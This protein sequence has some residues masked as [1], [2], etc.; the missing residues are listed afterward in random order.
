MKIWHQSFT[1]LE[2][3]PPY[4]AALAAH[5]K[6][7]ARPDTEVVLHGM[8]PDTY[9]TEYPG[10]DIKFSYFQTLHSQQFVLAALQAEQDGFDAL[11]I[12]TLPEPSFEDIRAIVDIPVV[13][14]CESA[15]LVSALVSR[16]CG[17][18]LFIRDMAPTIVRNVARMGLGDRFIGAQDVGFTFND[19]LAAYDDAT[20]LLQKFRAAARGMIAQGADA[21]IPGEA[22]L[23]V[24]L[25]RHGVTN[26][27]GVPVIDALAATV[28]MAELSVDLRRSSGLAPAKQGYFTAKPPRERL[29]ELLDFY[30]IGRLPLTGFGQW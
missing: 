22:P 19:V 6:R 5:F 11:A 7:V 18:L 28:K 1:V 2:K 24:L 29:L 10:N 9:R 4:A 23:C 20:A 25:A 15:M 12:T 14:Y 30:G 17:V 3:L 21:I 16:R 13:G 26:V 8:H 27:D